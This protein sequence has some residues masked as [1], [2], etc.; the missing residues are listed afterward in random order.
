[1]PHQNLWVAEIL[2]AQYPIV[3][4]RGCK[5]ELDPGN[6]MNAVGLA[7]TWCP[8]IGILCR[9]DGPWSFRLGM[10]TTFAGKVSGPASCTGLFQGRAACKPAL[11]PVCHKPGLTLDSYGMIMGWRVGCWGAQMRVRR[12]CSWMVLRVCYCSRRKQRLV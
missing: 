5:F 8:I 4:V 7:G 1:M 12:P 3:L 9:R 11:C 2:N 10:W 6:A